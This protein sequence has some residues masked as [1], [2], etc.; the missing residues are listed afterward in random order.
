MPQI[1]SILENN[2]LDFYRKHLIFTVAAMIVHTFYLFKI[3]TLLKCKFSFLKIFLPLPVSTTQIIKN[4]FHFFKARTIETAYDEKALTTVNENKEIV[5]FI[6]QVCA[7][8]HTHSRG[9]ERREKR[10]KVHWNLVIYRERPR[11]LT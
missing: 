9:V 4:W 8:T 1:S 3:L 7:R 6:F 10:V 2:Y 5:W 11:G